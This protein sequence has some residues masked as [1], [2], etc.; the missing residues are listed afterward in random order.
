MEEPLVWERGLRQGSTPV[1]GPCDCMEGHQSPSV[2]QSVEG[3]CPLL[4]QTGE[5]QT[6]MDTP[7][8]VRLQAVGV[9][10]EAAEGVG[11][12]MAGACAIGHADL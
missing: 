12:E 1:Q 3:G 2:L 7:L 4:P 11:K 8:Q 10:P 9:G 6:L 5:H